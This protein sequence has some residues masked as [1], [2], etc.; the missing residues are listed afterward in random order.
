MKEFGL[1]LIK[2]DESVFINIKEGII[3]ALYV[4]DILIIDLN[5]VGI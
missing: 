1:M 3:V 4:D 5:K 2:S